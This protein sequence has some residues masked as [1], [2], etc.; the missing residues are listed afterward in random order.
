MMQGYV[1]GARDGERMFNSSGEVAIKVD[2]TRGSK[3]LSLGTQLVPPG[4]GIPRHVHAYW[5][6]VIYVLDGG[7]IVTLNV[8]R[9]PLQKGATIFVPKGVWHGFENSRLWNCSSCGRL[10]QLDRRN[11]S[12]AISSPPGEPVKNFSRSK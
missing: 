7:G 12:G 10:R 3:D 9:V 2:P 6:E 8:E 4:V 5:D 11:S 1:L